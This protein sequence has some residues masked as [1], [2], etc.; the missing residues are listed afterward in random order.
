MDIIYFHSLYPPNKI[1]TELYMFKWSEQPCNYNIIGFSFFTFTF[2]LMTA[3]TFTS[4]ICFMWPMQCISH[5]LKK[6]SMLLHHLL[7]IMSY[8]CNYTLFRLILAFI[9]AEI[10]WWQISSI[11]LCMAVTGIWGSNFCQSVQKVGYSTAGYFILIPGDLYYL[12]IIIISMYILLNSR[13]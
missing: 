12:I 2:H 9:I 4:I 11:S 6:M 1:N 3:K 8:M 7:I 10:F 13:A 5:N